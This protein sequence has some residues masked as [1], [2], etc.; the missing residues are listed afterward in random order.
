MPQGI[1]LSYVVDWKM[2]M[3]K[4]PTSGESAEREP[5]KEPAGESAQELVQ[6]I[7]TYMPLAEQEQAR[8]AL[9]L[10]RETCE[11]VRGERPIP[12]FEHALA[13]AN[14]LAKMHIDAVG[15]SAGLV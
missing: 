1:V 11:G 5:L 7:A 8:K 2:P 10:A 15:V 13:I 9:Q 6:F 14:I 4:M 3:I 12:P